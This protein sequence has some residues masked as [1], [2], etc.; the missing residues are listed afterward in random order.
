ML[1][2][3]LLVLPDSA[4]V[5]LGLT[6]P[7][8][9]ETTFAEMRDFYVYGDFNNT[10]N[11]VDI[12]VSVFNE[13][14]QVVRTIQSCVN[15]TGITPD[16]SVNMSGFTSDTRWGDILAVEKIDSP[17]GYINGSNKLLVTRDYYVAF[18]QGGVTQGI[19]KSYYNNTSGTPVPLTNLTAGQYKI[20]VDVL[21]R[22]TGN[23]EQ[24][25]NKT[26]GQ[27][28][29]NLTRDI[30]FGLTNISLGMFTPA[31]NKQNVANYAYQHNL[32]VY[33]DYFPGYFQFGNAGYRIPSYWQSNNAIEVVNHL[34]GTKIDNTTSANNTMLIYNLGPTS[35][36][37]QLELAAIIEH[38]L[39]DLP[40][41]TFRYYDIGE[42]A[43]TWID[44]DS[45]KTRTLTGRSTYYPPYSRVIY[46]RADTS[47]QEIA[48]HT[49]S[50]LPNIAK[51]VDTTPYAVTV[52]P[53]EYLALYGVTRPINSS[54]SPVAESPF[55]Y[56]I[57]DQIYKYVYTGGGT[58]YTFEGLLTRIFV[59]ADGS[60]YPAKNTNYEFGHVFTAA[61]TA[62]MPLGTTTYTMQAYDKS[63]NPV[64]NATA[65]ISITVA[66]P[67]GD[68]NMDNAFRVLFETSGGSPLSPATDL[69]YGDVISPPPVPVKDGFTF[70]GWYT[71]EA[72]SK[73]WNFSSG[74]PGDITLYAGWTANYAS[75]TP[76]A[77]VPEVEE[78]NAGPQLTPAL[79]E[80]T[81]LQENSL[82]TSTAVPEITI[83]PTLTQAAA[84][85]CGA[86]LG[87][88]V[89]GILF[90]RRY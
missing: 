73:A 81:S 54:L 2:L 12:R 13:S 10:G 58:S 83:P 63:G 15:D 31:E 41:T 14:N 7:S 64:S 4:D 60:L 32:R 24:F 76:A 34:S 36:T 62:A 43:M 50:R 55:R 37:Y 84:P 27:L 44:E 5:T 6:Q 49:I 30:S 46:T 85:L 78:R 56:E 26:S 53:G 11:P 59:N 51:T 9:N 68:G 79:A 66:P 67:P 39:V 80:T 8:I 48:A 45:G 52:E 20:V 21:N 42:Y 86:L 33:F 22:T 16:T 47:S 89:A 88:L 40:W 35:T 75:P 90:R 65:T 19:T 1:L 18:V 70:G 25:K 3:S 23:P 77:G 69:S 87:I 71:D 38:D 57:N 28:V 61:E 72:C 29:N 17:G 82:V 74:I